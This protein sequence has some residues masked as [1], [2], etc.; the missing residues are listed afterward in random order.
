MG[1]TSGGAT[2]ELSI[3]VG[4]LHP[5]YAL[6]IGL[7]LGPV[8]ENT[9]PSLMMTLKLARCTYLDAKKMTVSCTGGLY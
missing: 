5:G 8:R 6:P 3:D 2:E 4:R 7:I 1:P 9:E